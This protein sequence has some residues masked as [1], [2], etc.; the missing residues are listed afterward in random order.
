MELTIADQYYTC[1][2]P[3][4][5]GGVQFSETVVINGITFLR[6]GAR[7]GAA[8]NLYDWV[9]YS[10]TRG[11]T[12]VSM[13]FVLHSMDPSVFPT[14]VPAYDKAAESAVFGQIVATFTW[15]APTHT[16]TPSATPVGGD[17]L[18]YTNPKYGFQL[19][20]PPQGQLIS[21]SDN[22]AKINLPF[23]PGTNLRDKYLE[24]QVTET[25]NP[26]R[27]SLS[28]VVTASETVT[29]NRISFLRETGMD[30]AAGNFYDW[31]AYSTLRGTTCISLGFVLHSLDPGALPTPV[32]I[33]DKAAESVVFAQVVCTCSWLAPT[34]TQKPT[35]TPV[36]ADWLTYLNPKY[37][38]QLRY[39]KE[40]QLT[41][42]LDNYAKILLPIIPGTNLQEKY[43]EVYVAENID[44]CQSP[45]A[46]TS[47]L[48]SSETVVI[49][50]ITYL[51]QI[52]GDAVT[53]QIYQWVAYSTARGAACVSQ[54]FVL[55]SINPGV[56][57]TPPPLFDEALE[58]AVFE[59]IVATF[60]W[61][62]P[63][64]TPTPTPSQS[65]TPTPTNTPLPGPM[66]DLVVAGMSIGYQNAGCLMPG[67]LYGLWV[68]VSNIGQAPAAAFMV[69]VNDAQSPVEGLG[70]GES[71][72]V[73]LNSGTMGGQL[74]ALVDSASQIQESD[75]TNNS[76]TQYVPI[77]T[78]PLPCTA[79]PTALSGPYAVVLV[80]YGGSLNVYSDAGAGNLV[81]GS[82]PWNATGIMGTGATRF[83]D[84]SEWIQ[85]IRT[86]DGTGWVDSSFL[87]EQVSSASFCGDGR[88]PAMIGQLKQSIDWSDGSTFASLVSPRHGV[89]VGF[90][91]HQTVVTYTQPNSSGIFKD[92]T[93]VNWGA[94]PSLIPDVGTFAAVVQPDMAEVFGSSYQTSCNDPSY[95]DMFP[96]A[97]PYSN[98]HYYAVVKP[99]ANTFD[100][101]VWLIGFEY[102]D[103][104]PFLFGT[105]HFVWEP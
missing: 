82:Y 72:S 25:L 93:E 4:G 2:S 1:R 84:G 32:V 94:G 101:K 34:D 52:G 20:Y 38:F 79:T 92:P 98:V 59:Q 99:P 66:P 9:A 7:E 35:P 55:H 3:L 91:Q 17:W 104:R 33:F 48:Q 97:W 57:E 77:P 71:V 70:A 74:T 27:T 31:V 86:D 15:L 18:T 42:Q 53:S 87:T 28:G 69:Q 83:A 78:Q 12:C 68:R 60:T 54:N 88:I 67:D 50:G 39:P 5:L 40:S 73:L 37:G 76:L 62:T 105:V 85:V 61:L 29:I 14:P 21:Q 43:L 10:T 11:T 81:V 65:A 75:E 45:L 100:W 51:K 63:T 6:E 102:V 103:G 58:K 47:M 30:G 41:G 13:G 64:E 8:G 24:I 23:T 22:Y 56:F 95:A 26:C 89:R 49:N 19:R 36:S 80:S 46:T 96:S 90:W 16:P 44:P